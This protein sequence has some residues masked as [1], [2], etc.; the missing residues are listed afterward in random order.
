MKTMTKH[1]Y[2][3]LIGA[4]VLSSCSRPVAY[5]QRGPVEN[6][7]TAKTETIAPTPSVVSTPSAQPEVVTEAIA[8]PATE[9]AEQVA[10]A[11]QTMNQIEAYV[12]NDSRLAS[13]KKLTKRME[14]VKNLLNSAPV[15]TTAAPQTKASTKKMTLLER[16]ATKQINN[17]IKHKLSPERT[18]ATSMLTIG[19]IVAAAGL[20]LLLI[21][22][23]FGAAIGAIALVVG[24]VLI[25]LELIK[26]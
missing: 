21:G 22:N 10:Q 19:L 1:L 2:A 15:Q 23:G 26:Q 17:K 9:P 12:R 4:A 13:N 14:K 16:V 7:H 18:M 25:I 20:L 24:L 5:F 6:Y 8:T 3:A 11:K